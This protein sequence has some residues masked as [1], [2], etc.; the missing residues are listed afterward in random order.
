M[1]S[2]YAGVFGVWQYKNNAFPVSKMNKRAID[3]RPFSLFK[4]TRV[5]VSMFYTQGRQNAL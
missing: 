3:D 4:K 5:R 2:C 1:G